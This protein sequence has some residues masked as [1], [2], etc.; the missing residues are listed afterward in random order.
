MEHPENLLTFLKN[1]FVS[2]DFMPRR[3]RY[4]RRPEGTEIVAL[5]KSIISGFELMEKQ[6]GVRISFE[7]DPERAFVMLDRYLYDRILFNLISNA[8]KFTPERGKVTIRLKV[9]GGR[10]RLSVQDTGVGIAESDI[11]NLFQTFRQVKGDVT[12]RYEGTRL[13][14]A[15]VKESSK[16]LGGDVFVESQ[17]GKGSTFTVECLAPPAEETALETSPERLRAN[18]DLERFNI[19]AV[20]REQRIIELKRQVNELARALGKQAPYDLSFIED[21]R[22]PQTVKG[23]NPDAR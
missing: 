16:L 4:L 11:K 14:L 5:T 19:L 10:L 9:A 23:V 18:E 6:E 8:I 20:D 7:A 15:M 21:D 22:R 13:G 12:R 1:L 17:L 3:H 2:D